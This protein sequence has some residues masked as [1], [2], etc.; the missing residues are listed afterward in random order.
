MASFA[1]GKIQAY[2][3][4]PEL[5]A[6]DD[7]EQVIVDFI[8]GAKTRLDIA[9]QELDS[10][11][12]AQAILDARWRGVKVTVFLE[13]DYLR[14]DLAGNPLKLPT[15]RAGETPEEALRRVQWHT[16]ETDL[17]VNREILAALLRSDVEVKGHYN[18]KIFHQKFI[19]R[20]YD[21]KATPTSALLSGS[22]NFTWTDTHRNLNNLFV[23]RNAYICRQ[24]QAEVEQLQR[25]SFGRGLHGEVPKT[26]D[27][28]GVPVRVLFAPT[29]PPSWRS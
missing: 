16:D 15:P 24:Y 20:D 6:A 2:I 23:F 17:A 7:L 11:P 8:A 12:I 3:G 13:Q 29:T 19:L 27:L 28:S 18:P 26:Y 22:A 5:G 9:I 25:G 14:S 4:P 10:R 1:G 21:G